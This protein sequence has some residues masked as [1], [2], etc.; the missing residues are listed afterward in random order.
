MRSLAKDANQP[1]AE[2]DRF[3]SETFKSRGIGVDRAARAALTCVEHYL[4][5][6]LPGFEDSWRY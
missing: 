3:A 1:T 2:I 4:G 6:R 5:R